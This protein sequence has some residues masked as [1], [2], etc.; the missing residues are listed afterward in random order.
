M[1][2]PSFRYSALQKSG[3][4][5]VLAS[6][7]DLSLVRGVCDSD[8]ESAIEQLQKSTIAIERQTKTLRTQQEAVAAL[9]KDNGQHYAARAAAE[10]TQFRAWTTENDQ[11]RSA[12]SAVFQ[13]VLEDQLNSGRLMSYFRI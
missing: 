8:I 1:L 9:V 4:S 13:N 12:V 7:Q 10:S 3:E 11:T 5:E 2:S 6:S